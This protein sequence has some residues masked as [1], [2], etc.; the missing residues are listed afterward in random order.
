MTY[1]LFVGLAK[2]VYIRCMSGTFGREITKYTVMYGVYIR[3]WP[4]LTICVVSFGIEI[5]KYTVFACNLGQPSNQDLPMGQ[6]KVIAPVTHNGYLHDLLTPHMP[7]VFG[8][9]NTC[10]RGH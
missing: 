9:C 4:T 1:L 10:H 8:T 3:F 5:C 7:R 2:N 6:W